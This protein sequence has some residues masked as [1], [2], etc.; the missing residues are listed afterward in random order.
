MTLLALSGSQGGSGDRASNGAG[1]E[2]VLGFR[3]NFDCSQ[4]GVVQLGE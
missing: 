4:F 3:Q 2:F 1:F